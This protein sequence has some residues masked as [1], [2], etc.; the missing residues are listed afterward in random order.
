VALKLHAE[1]ELGSY[2]PG[3]FELEA[4]ALA[5]LNSPYVV[6]VY[7]VGVADGST[8]LVMELLEG[9]SLE[10][11]LSR[12]VRLPITM[13]ASLVTDICKGLS[14]THQAGLVHRDIKPANVFLARESGNE[15]VKLLDFGIATRRPQTE[16]SS[17]DESAGRWL[18]TALYMSPEQLRGQAV[19]TRSD[20]WALGIVSYRILTGRQPFQGSTLTQ[21]AHAICSEAHVPV[22]Q[23]VPAL[24]GRVDAFFERALAKEPAQRFA[25]AEEFATAFAALPASHPAPTRI[26]LLDDEPDMKVLFQQR[27]RRELR[28]G[29]YE[30]HFAT[31]GRA[32]LEELRTRR[33]IDVVLTDLNMPGMDGLTFLKQVPEINPFV[34]V[35]VV[36]AYGDMTNIRTAMNRGAFDFLGKPIDFSDL[37]ATIQKCAA[38]VAVVRQALQS[39]EENQMMRVLIGHG[40]ADRWLTALRHGPISD[41]ITTG[42]AAFID[43]HGFARTLVAPFPPRAFERLN[44]YFALFARELQAK[45]GKVSRFVGD[46][47]LAIFEGEDHFRRAVDACLAIRAR[48][49]TLTAHERDSAYGVCIGID[50]G[51]ILMG[52]L[53]TLAMGH[54]EPCV[55]GETV[56]IAA[57]LLALAKKD[58]MLI[59][60]GT[61]PLLSA[62]YQYEEDAQRTIST[63]DGIHAVASILRRSTPGS[64]R[65]A[66]DERTQALS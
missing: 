66:N 9:E 43:V 37:Q 31:D 28:D 11:H 32:G 12:T 23:L 19:D 47:L 60:T 54:V 56:S 16:D 33:D 17:A 24:D 55:L 7:D 49:R 41:Q 25:N 62:D 3:R 26:L 36:S 40:V 27:F 6:R 65:L 42:T 14:A 15:L 58:E 10:A 35:V 61:L 38:H 51:Q 39:A 4:R 59:S 30:L 1:G 57:R 48:V 21:L 50:S 45:D 29:R 63:S 44:D 8:F 5:N 18:G 52:P 22:S 53:G 13:A 2:D 20:L 64:G 34:R 46:A